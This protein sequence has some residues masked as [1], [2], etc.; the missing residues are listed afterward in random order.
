MTV[1]HSPNSQN[2]N[3][4]QTM[5]GGNGGPRMIGRYRVDGVL[6]KGAMG[7]VYRGYDELIDR[8]VAIKTIHAELL[9]GGPDGDWHERFRR[10]ARAAARCQHPNIVTIYEYGE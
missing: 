5:T 8:E 10:E 4:T 2:Q 9:G 6:G 1:S 3:Q 7:V